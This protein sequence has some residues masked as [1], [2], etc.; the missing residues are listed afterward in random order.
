MIGVKKIK[1]DRILELLDCIIEPDREYE[2][3]YNPETSEFGGA[4]FFRTK[5]SEL[6]F[7]REIADEKNN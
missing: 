4:H 1:K 6:E 7:E 5:E 3:W 2:F